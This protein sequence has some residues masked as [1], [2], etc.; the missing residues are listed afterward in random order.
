MYCASQLQIEV[1]TSIGQIIYAIFQSLVLI[2]T[3]FVTILAVKTLWKESILPKTTK[4]LLFATLTYG[5]LHGLAFSNFVATILYRNFLVTQNSSCYPI[6]TGEDCS[7]VIQGISLGISGNILIQT[8]LCFDRLLATIFGMKYAKTLPG[9][10]FLALVIIGS[11]ST[12]PILRNGQT[13]D[14]SQLYC[15]MWPAKMATSANT[16]LAS[17]FYLSILNFMLNMGL[18]RYNH[19]CEKKSHFKVLERYQNI[20]TL[21]ST[22]MI[23]YIITCQLISMI[24]YSGGVWLMRQHTKEISYVLYLNIIVWLYM[25]T[26][27]NYRFSDTSD[28]FC[29]STGSYYLFILESKKTTIINLDLEL[30]SELMKLENIPMDCESVVNGTEDFR[31]IWRAK[32]WNWHFGDIEKELFETEDICPVIE[33]YFSF[34]KLALSEE[35]KEYPL[36]YGLVV[37]K[38]IVQVIMQLSIFYQ[39]QH[40]FCITVDQ[41]SPEIYKNVIQSLPKC[42]ENMNVFIGEESEWGSFGILKN[43]YT[44][45]EHLTK[46]KNDWK[47]YQYLSGTDLPMRTNLE[48]VRIF[49]ALNG[50]INTD[51]STFE[52]NRYKNMEGVIPPMP[53]YKSSMSV[54]LPRDAANYIVDSPKVKKL[55]QYL[56]NTWIPDESFWS[57][58]SGSPKLL[59]VPGAVRV[60]DIMWLRQHFKA[61]PADVN[62]VDDVGTS[63]IGRY[64]VWAWQKDCYGKIKDYSCVFGVQDIE[65]IVTRP[66]LVAHKLYLAFEP[67]AF[68]CLFKEIRRRTLNPSDFDAKSYSEMPTVE[69]LNGVSITQLTHP[70]WLVR[71]SFYNPEQEDQDRNTI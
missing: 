26:R 13:L 23:S 47:Y 41:N 42:F 44:C 56:K 71:D 70:N 4:I 5:V 55:L 39:P 24:I 35:E 58:V 29:S 17:I 51:V 21:Q 28:K 20:E 46:S 11:L 25:L 18:M 52:T 45:F 54:V 53:I 3:I 68:M 8:F 19:I 62:T 65:E 2:F 34:S 48:M 10:I 1:Y 38:N 40:L 69:L 64:Q 12:F 63:Y 7:N 30:K 33:K 59:P 66:E 31:K 14:E 67:A 27:D 36:A 37:F 61:R 16:F 43:V 32:N 60:R 49:K 6:P 9:I 57:T 50:S 22:K 15:I